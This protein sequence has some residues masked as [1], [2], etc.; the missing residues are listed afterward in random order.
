[1]IGPFTWDETVG[2]YRDARG[3]FVTRAE[4]RAAL[5][6]ALD[7]AE[8]RI[9]GL[10]E[11]LRSGRMPLG[12]W[13]DRMATELKDLHLYSAASARGGWGQ[14]SRADLSRVA[15]EVESQYRSVRQPRE[16]VRA[17]GPRHLPPA[18]RRAAGGAGHDRGA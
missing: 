17:V 11:E 5:D 9:V 14:M 18:R 6:A 8:R 12:Q 13:R 16:A 7:T 2:R 4:I 3:R 1:M 10:G 15:R